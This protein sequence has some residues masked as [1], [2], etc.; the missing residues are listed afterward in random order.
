MYI[1]I[2]LEPDILIFVLYNWIFGGI[3]VLALETK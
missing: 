1:A 2:I 3:V